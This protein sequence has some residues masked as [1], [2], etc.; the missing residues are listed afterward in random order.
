MGKG[1]K[2]TSQQM[3]N[4]LSLYPKPR[5]RLHFPPPLIYL[6]TFVLRL[7][8]HRP[9]LRLPS[10]VSETSRSEFHLSSLSAMSVCKV[11][12]THEGCICLFTYLQ[13]YLNLD[14]RS[15]PFAGSCRVRWKA[16][17]ATHYVGGARDGYGWLVLASGLLSLVGWPNFFSPIA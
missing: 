12:G 17:R 8:T 3:F 11:G 2:T 13:S 7:S 15:R 5:L 10:R 14:R 1:V 9:S 6:N 16:K 4:G